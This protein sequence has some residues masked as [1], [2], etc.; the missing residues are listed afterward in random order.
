[1]ADARQANNGRKVAVITG[2]TSGIGQA[3]AY[4]MA[5]RGYDILVHGL[6]NSGL[7]ETVSTLKKLGARAEVVIGDIRQPKI[8]TEIV[9]KAVAAFG[10]ID[11]LANNAGTGFFR[12]AAETS[13]ED[14][15][16]VFA[17]H[18]DAPFQMCRNAYP[19]LRAVGGAIVN[20]SSVT[21]TH[22]LPS[23]VAYGTA[24]SA[25]IGLTKNLAAEWAPD[26]VRVNAISPGTIETPLVRAN[27]ESGRT[28]VSKERVIS[29]MPIGRLG[30]PEEV[31]KV[32]GFLLS[33]DAS[34][35]TGHVVYIDGGWTSSGGW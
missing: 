27:F 12:P 30:R 14:W 24:K 15:R 31:A 9:E 4:H 21:A 2:S 6:D 33:D 29:R 25:I 20:T 32:T 13:D 23:R 34:Y 10:R 5:G 18:V 11:G 17:L 3:M 16:S 19:H 1:M 8:T 22:W 7:D 35:V 28:G 26:G